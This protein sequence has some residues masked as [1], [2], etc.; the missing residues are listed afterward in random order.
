MT[1]LNSSLFF[2]KKNNNNETKDKKNYKNQIKNSNFYNLTFDINNDLFSSNLL[3]TFDDNS[4]VS[5]DFIIENLLHSY[6]NK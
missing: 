5:T 4:K 6:E 1:S 3:N 2:S